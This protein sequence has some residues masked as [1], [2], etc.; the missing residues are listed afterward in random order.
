MKPNCTFL[1]LNPKLIIGTIQKHHKNTHLLH[2]LNPWL[3]ELVRA[4]AVSFDR[5][6]W[7]TWSWGSASLASWASILTSFSIG[8]VHFLLLFFSRSCSRNGLPNTYCA[9][10]VKPALVLFDTTLA[11]GKV[12][13]SSTLVESLHEDKDLEG[14]DF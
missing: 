14:A 2:Q 11:L 12:R 6:F 13:I 7:E 9:L 8:L 4:A 5:L 3:V 10:L 1:T